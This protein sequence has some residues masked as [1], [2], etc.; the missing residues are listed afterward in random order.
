MSRF[1]LL[2][3]YMALIANILIIIFMR[4]MLHTLP[5]NDITISCGIIG[6]WGWISLIVGVPY[7]AQKRIVVSLLGIGLVVSGGIIGAIFT[8]IAFV[9]AACNHDGCF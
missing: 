5:D 8:F 3:L 1:R 4:P 2:T 9:V 7:F 6:I